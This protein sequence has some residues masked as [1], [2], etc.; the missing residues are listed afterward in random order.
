MFM[1][2]ILPMIVIAAS[3]AAVVAIFIAPKLNEAPEPA[4]PAAEINVTTVSQPASVQ[5]SFAQAAI[6]D[7]EDD[8][9]YWTLASV[10]GTS[11][12]FMVDTGASTVALTFLDAQRLGLEPDKLSFPIFA[13]A[14]SKLRMLKR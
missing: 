12:K 7:R 9:H 2:R 5:E 10:D 14:M 1:E 6:I 3:L 8:G 13:S 4:A 11:V